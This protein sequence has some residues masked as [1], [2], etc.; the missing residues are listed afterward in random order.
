LP[1]ILPD[2]DDFKPSAQYYSPLQKNEDWVNIKKIDGKSGKR[3][4]NVMPQ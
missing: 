2:L 4:I 1:L 3:D